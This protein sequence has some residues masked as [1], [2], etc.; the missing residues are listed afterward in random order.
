MLDDGVEVDLERDCAREVPLGRDQRV[1]LAD[2]AD[3]LAAGE[4]GRAAARMQEGLRGRDDLPR[5]AQRVERDPEQAFQGE[6]L[7]ALPR[8]Q[9]AEGAMLLGQLGA[10]VPVYRA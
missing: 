3:G 4:D 10:G 1:Q 7:R 5:N 6:E 9:P 8:D 2:P